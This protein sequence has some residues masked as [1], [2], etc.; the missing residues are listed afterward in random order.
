MFENVK[1]A[2]SFFLDGQVNPQWNRCLAN[3]KGL[4]QGLDQWQGWGGQW[5]DAVG[6]QQLHSASVQ[7]A[8]DLSG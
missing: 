8:G 4:D 7:Q 6:L 3:R 2:E 1:K 5:G